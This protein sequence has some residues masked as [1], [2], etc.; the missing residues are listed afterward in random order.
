MFRNYFKTALRALLKN[1]TYSLINIVGLSVGTLCCIYILLY[2][3]EQYSYDKH[4]R[5][6]ESI[7]RITTDLTLSGDRRL[8]ATSSPPIAPAMKKEFAE[9]AEYT[10][11]V[12]TIS[13]KKHLLLYNDKS[14]Y[15]EDAVFVDSAFFNVFTYHFIGGIPS[16]AVTDPYSLVLM[17][18]TADKLFGNEDPVGKVI[19]IDNSYGRHAFK[20]TGVIDERLGKTHIHA[21]LFMSMNS[22]GIGSYAADNNTWSGNNFASSYV[23]LNPNSDAAALDKKLPAFVNKYGQ[24]QLKD[25]GMKKDIH[26][27]PITA[28]HTSGGYA[29][30]LSKTTSTSFLYL[31]ML[32]AVMIQ[33]IA[34]INFMNLSTARASKRA[35]EV[36]VRKVVGADRWDLVKQFLS[37]S[38][39][40]SLTGVLIALPLLLLALPYLNRIT[41][42]GVTLS[43]FS[44]YQTW[45]ILLALVLTT[46]LIAGSY[47]AFYLSAFKAIKVIKGN[48]T[49]HVSAS[50]IRRSLVVF[51]FSLS[52]VLIICIIIIQSQLHFIKNKDLGFDKN[53][54]LVF[55][56]YTDAPKK[57][58]PAFINDVRALSE[59]TSVSRANNFLGQFVPN[60]H[61][62]FLEGGNR[63]SSADAQNMTTDEHFVKTN[64]IKLVSGRDFRSND[65]GRVLINETLAKRLGLTPA[66][67]VGTKLYSDGD[68][69]GTYSVEVAGV[70]KD[71]NYNSLRDDIKPFMLVYGADANLPIVVLSANSPDYKSLIGKI[72]TAWKRNFPSVPF[73]YKFL[74]EEIQHQYEAELTVSNIIN[75]FTLMAV[76]ISCL[77]LFGLA[78]FSAEQR[79]K[80]IGIRKVLG[81]SSLNLTA[82]LS[83][84]FLKLVLVAILIASPVAWWAMN[85]W[86][87]AFTYRVPI[88][89]WMFCAAGTIAIIIALITVSFQAIK[90]AVA[91]PVKSLRT[92]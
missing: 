58:I 29:H 76:L 56:F 67:A 41:E 33:V 34:C 51:Q 31:L 50:G 52:I 14:L 70:M 11:I 57:N 66:K 62:V 3:Q 46:G 5:Q 90:A 49:N 20:I 45:L 61:G 87:Q 89:W 72:E 37:E 12:P 9:V 84:D 36:G 91:N 59:V 64:G 86:L 16:R 55:N 83:A 60:D 4:H 15:E 35:K 63:A 48:F 54:K 69:G 19:D 27:Q 92:E 75:S 53:Q 42:S 81:A 85:K 13:V 26:L 71:F 10:R 17:K 74:D 8:N 39:L 21:N 1:K 22:G 44:S 40:L 24:V 30:E 43:L 68:G 7:Y 32:I 73:E 6:A 80:E 2:V 65:S 38:M 77:G 82:L 25:A 79:K 18:G 78:A 28:I 88:S 47:P 23:K